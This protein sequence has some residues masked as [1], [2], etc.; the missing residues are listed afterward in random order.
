MATT[1]Q[2]TTVITTITTAST[3]TFTNPLFGNQ[4]TGTPIM[5]TGSVNLQLPGKYWLPEFDHTNPDIW[6][7]AADIIF[8]QNG[9]TSEQAQFSGLLQVLDVMRMKN[10][11]SI[12]KNKNELQP[13]TKAKAILLSLYGE[14]EEQKFEQLLGSLSQAQTNSN[15]TPSLLLE[16]IRR[17]G[18]GVVN[19][20]KV[21]RK[22]WMQRLPPNIKSHVATDERNNLSLDKLVRTADLVH[23]I[24]NPTVSHVASVSQPS[25]SAE[26]FLIQNLLTAVTSL[27]NEVNAIKL[28]MGRDS[29][30]RDRRS[31]DPG[32]SRSSA[33]HRNSW[34]RSR[35]RHTKIINNVCWYHFK[36]DSEAR[37][38][39]KGCKHFQRSG[40]KM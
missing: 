6:F 36:F 18:C 15:L 38:C 3:T 19:D 23:R 13:F 14:F 33:D 29:R 24:L 27:T 2:S 1:E 20:E 5:S 39:V 22:M 4:S 11:Q 37:K 17:L 16:E 40:N 26:T 8:N 10:I 25:Q 32:Y 34:P 35:S 21:I 9:I 12:I 30:P 31:P 28:N 7:D